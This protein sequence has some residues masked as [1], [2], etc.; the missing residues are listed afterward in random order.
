[1][2]I[3]I[4]VFCFL[5]LVA[6]NYATNPES[7]V[8]DLNGV[9][10]Q[11]EVLDADGKFIVEWVVDFEEK[12]VVFEVSAETTGFVGF[13]VSEG[14][15]MTGADIVIGG[16]YPNGTSYFADYHGT[17]DKTPDV[18]ARQDWE[19]I[20]AF[21]NSTHTFLKISRPL[22]SCDP[23]D[24]PITNDTISMIWAIGNTDDVTYHLGKRGTIAVNILDPPSPPVD[25]S[26]FKNW[27]LTV[28]MAMPNKSYSYWCTIYKSPK[29]SGKNHIVG[30]RP[31]LKGPLAVKHTHHFV[32]YKC[33]APPGSTADGTFGPFSDEPGDECYSQQSMDH[34]PTQLCADFL[35]VWGSGGKDLLLPEHV[36]YPVGEEETRMEYFMLEIHY[37]NPE[38]LP[39]ARFETGVEI[40]YTEKLRRY[41]A[42]MMTIGHTVQ[43]SLLIPPKTPE[44]MIVGHCSSECTNIAIPPK[45]IKIFNLLL[46]THL[47]GRKMKLRQFRNG[48]ELPWVSNDDSYHFNYQ[49]N[50]PLREERVVLP[51]DHLTF[52]CIYDTSSRSTV[53][54]AGYSTTDE[55]CETFIW[56]YPRVGLESCAS[57]YPIE[58]F[59]NKFGI[60]DVEWG[61]GLDGGSQPIIRKPAY[62]ANRT[63]EQALSEFVEWTPELKKEIQQQQHYSDHTSVCSVRPRTL[64]EGYDPAEST[65]EEEEP[66]RL[67]NYPKIESVY[68][69][70]PQCSEENMIKK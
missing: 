35:F 62:M 18:D 65:E 33:T 49:K 23:H 30:F 43:A 55:M 34:R 58:K 15:G 50:R 14:G 26:S 54:V 40:F 69:P 51:G 47:A 59:Y 37:D 5:N 32:V 36:G 57:T 11:K 6:L 17:G 45:G 4:L 70:V 52:E 61:D 63:F 66:E 3:F 44:H 60:K 68:K 25:V 53:T 22:D 28:D 7:V 1:M 19:L 64:P 56:Y 31:L 10:K 67:V 29:F 48:T 46:H 12:K 38:V 20:S 39:D 8:A 13:G 42:A 2:K 41:D 21:E 9:E 24:V 16:I 27:Q